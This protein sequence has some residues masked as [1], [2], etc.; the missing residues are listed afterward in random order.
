M[1]SALNQAVLPSACLMLARP[2][3]ALVPR[4]LELT[5][6]KDPSALER[7]VKVGLRL[8][9]APG[10]WAPAIAAQGACSGLS[11]SLAALPAALL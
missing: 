8:L 10:R 1:E 7:L 9:H 4:L 2:A 5:G 3:A 6:A 11:T